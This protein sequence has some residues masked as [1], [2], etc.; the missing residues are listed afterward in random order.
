MPKQKIRMSKPA[1]LQY[2]N[3]LQEQGIFSFVD[4]MGNQYTACNECLKTEK[5]CSARKKGKGCMAGSINP[6]F[7]KQIKGE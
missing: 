3:N 1:Y 5:E 4:Q 7:E 6:K 2:R